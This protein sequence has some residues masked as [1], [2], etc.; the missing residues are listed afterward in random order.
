MKHEDDMNQY[1]SEKIKMRP[2]N[3]KK[4]AQKTFFAAVSAVLFGVIACLTFV[5][6]IPIFEDTFFPEERATIEFSEDTDFT[7]DEMNPEEMLLQDTPDLDI[8]EEIE[9][10]I[11]ALLPVMDEVSKIEEAEG[12]ATE[13]SQL[14]D[15]WKKGYVTVSCVTSEVSFLDTTALQEYSA[16]GAIIADNGLEL[17]ILVDDSFYKSQGSLEIELYNGTIYRGE[18]YGQDSNSGLMVVAINKQNIPTETLENLEIV[19]LGT[20]NHNGLLGSMVVAYGNPMG[21]VDSVLYGVVSAT[22]ITV[23]AEDMNYYLVYTDMF[24]SEN[25]AGFLCELDGAICGILT[26]K[27]SEDGME[28]FITAIGISELKKTI[29][30]MSNRLEIPYLG[31]ESVEISE[32]SYQTESIPRGAYVAKITLD[33]PAMQAGIL[34]GDFIVELDGKE[35]MTISQYTTQLYS[36]AANS[37]VSVVVARKTQGEYREIELE[38]TLGSL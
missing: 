20:S 15:S 33:S 31:I 35:I 27:Y 30:K 36:L 4:I 38:I 11:E 13:F 8:E 25:Q 23:S 17:L 19:S 22:K 1:V 3:K 24:G 26:S 18:I 7:I 6:L 12:L 32:T 10:R 37:T 2:L 28:Q 9:E 29:E 14:V 34:P 16:T 5:L 21:S